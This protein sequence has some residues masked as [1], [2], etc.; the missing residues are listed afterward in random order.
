M[1][2]STKQMLTDLAKT[3]GV[4]VEKLVEFYAKQ[5]YASGIADIGMGL[6]LLTVVVFLTRT[7]LK[8]SF[9]DRVDDMVPYEIVVFVSGVSIIACSIIGLMSLHSGFVN[10]MAPEAYAITKIVSVLK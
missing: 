6:L 10:L 7:I 3:L 8:E 5:G 1:D 2:E 4:A 9:K